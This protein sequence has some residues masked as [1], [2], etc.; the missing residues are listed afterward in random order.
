MMAFGL[1]D[2][3]GTFQGAMNITLAPGLRKFVIVF[4]DDILVY[5]AT[6]EEHIAHLIQ[7][8]QW[9]RKDPWQ[10]KLSRQSIH[11]LG[12]VIS[13][14]GLS[15][16]PTKIQAV[17]DW[18]VPSSVKALRGFLGTGSSCSTSAFSLF[19]WLWRVVNDRKFPAGIVFF[20]HTTQPA[21]LHEPATK[22]TIQT[23]RL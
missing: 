7:V 5:S 20:S 10:L 21:V 2:T 16:D 13:G 14:K 3:P 19:V 6:F 11:Y 8:L 1:T 22:R 17:R 23:N 18:P 4:F 15:T 12:H 9:L